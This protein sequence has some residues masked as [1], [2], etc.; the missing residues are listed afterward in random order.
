MY[1]LISLKIIIINIE[2]DGICIKT[3]YIILNNSN[4]ENLKKEQTLV[5]IPNSI[6]LKKGSCY[7]ACSSLLLS[8]AIFN[9]KSHGRVHLQFV[10]DKRL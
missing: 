10:R 6:A 8:M 5:I 4:Q 1:L 9:S 2:M 7:F 3:Y